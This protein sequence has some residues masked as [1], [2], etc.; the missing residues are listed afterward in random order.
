M[1]R[2]LAMLTSHVLAHLRRARLCIRHEGRL[3]G[4]E[5]Q[6]WR[7]VRTQRESCRRSLLPILLSS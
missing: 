5:G 6:R 1:A 3:K 7:G 4:E 2:P